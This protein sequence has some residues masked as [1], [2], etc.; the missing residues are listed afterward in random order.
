MFRSSPIAVT[1]PEDCLSCLGQS[2]SFR[3]PFGFRLLA[4]T[5]G[6]VNAGGG[7]AERGNCLG[8]GLPAG[9]IEFPSLVAG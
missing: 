9:W 6:T 8:E 3:K 2:P 5:A 1:V 7:S 4:L